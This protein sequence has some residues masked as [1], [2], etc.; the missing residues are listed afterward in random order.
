MGLFAQS[1][2]SP[3]GSES[4]DPEKAAQ[5][6]NV[7]ADGKYDSDSTDTQSLEA[8]NEKEIQQHPDQVTADAH[9][10]VQKA[11]AAALVWS[12]P[13]L[14]FIYVWVW[15]V[16]F[17]LAFQS[18]MQLQA[19]QIG[20]GSQ[21]SLPAISTASILGAIIG[22]VLKLPIAKT[23]NLWG[24]AE[25]WFLFL[26]VYIL[27]II[28]SASFHGTA[29]YSAGY[30]L[31]WIGYDAIYL[32]CDIFI[33]DTSGLRNR[34]FGFAFINTPF[35]ITA[36]TGS[37][38]IQSFLDIASWRWTVGAFAII[39][40][41]AMAP[42]GIMFKFYERKAKKLGLFKSRAS[43]RTVMQ[44]IV[45]YFHEFDLVG[46]FL[47]MAA[48]VLFLLPFSLQTNARVTY[49]SG[50]FIAMIVVGLLLFPVFA[51]W[52]K[53]FARTH[54]IRWELLKER[55][56][57]G[58]SMTAIAIQFSF[59]CW[60][61]YFNQFLQV[62]YGLSIAEAGYM[63]NCYTVGSSFWGVVFGL[64]LRYSR[65]FKYECLCFGLP[66][67]F[68]GAGLTIYFRGQSG[69]DDIGYLIMCQIFIAF[70]CGTLVIGHQMAAMAAS[71]REGVPMVLAML[72][73]FSSVGQ[74]IG[75]AVI[76]AIYAKVFPEAI[77]SRLPGANETLANELFLGG[78]VT[79]L[80]YANG[81]PERIASNYAWGEVQK[82]GGVSATCVLII[83]IPGIAMWKNYRL[84]KQQNKGT[85]L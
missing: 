73:L 71:D 20:L 35:I 53:F 50:A 64:W 17:M 51:A 23:L 69:G 59:Y 28:V 43:G 56:I 80:T 41:V 3:A 14:I 58:A 72:G 66:L 27:G 76:A 7:T 29:G 79:Q 48:F 44:S 18:S 5:Q 65:R 63:L 24:R 61:Q 60:D 38:A 37:L 22:G 33:A 31:Y 13:A 11:E 84:D 81:T 25:A 12:K 57:V 6:P 30:T 52:E 21:Y 55:T 83:A 67:A 46:A 36:F 4:A 8:R 45:H 32:I 40:V 9:V 47:V 74:A 39:Q 70:G 10:G 19:T 82:W 34:A 2:H 68:L 42:L 62:V 78:T 75:S 16:V 85:V 49:G 26:G 77:S 15:I 54:F 1:K